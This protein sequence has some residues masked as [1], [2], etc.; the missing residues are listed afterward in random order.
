MIYTPCCH[1]ELISTC[2][3]ADLLFKFIHSNSFEIMW[4]FNLMLSFYDLFYVYC[5][6]THVNKLFSDEIN[7]IFRDLFLEQSVHTHCLPMKEDGTDSLYRCL[8]AWMLP[9]RFIYLFQFY[10]WI[11]SQNLILHTTQYST[12]PLQS[13]LKGLHICQKKTMMSS[14]IL[15]TSV[16]FVDCNLLIWG[17]NFRQNLK[18][19]PEA[20]VCH[21]GTSLIF[22]SK[23]R[24]QLKRGKTFHT[25]WRVFLTRSVFHSH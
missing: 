15:E 11:A 12:H 25:V 19:F 9:S 10:L 3:D 5:S 4:K 1:P 17:W 2:W 14:P 20:T 24:S 6:E 23:Q 21:I 8:M 13:K 22:E 18:E 16:Y 7:Y